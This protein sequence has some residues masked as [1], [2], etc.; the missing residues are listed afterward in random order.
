MEQ[1]F[2]DGHIHSYDNYID[3]LE[4][5]HNNNARYT[6]MSKYE[7]FNRGMNRQIIARE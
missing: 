7:M 1:R 2:K 4:E 3:L 5:K 6:V